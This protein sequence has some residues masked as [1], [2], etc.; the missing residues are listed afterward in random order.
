MRPQTWLIVVLA[1]AFGGVAAAGVFLLSTPASGS[2][3]KSMIVVVT[4]DVPRGTP[5]TAESVAVRP[6]NDQV[7]AGVLTKIADAIGR[8][9]LV[10]LY[11]EEPLLDAKLAPKGAG[12][13]LASLLKRGMRAVTIPTP[14]V[15]TNVAGF[16]EV[17]SHVDILWT[18]TDATRDDRSAG[19]D[20]PLLEDVE[21]LAVDDK[22]DSAATGKPDG[23]AIKSVTVQLK[24]EDAAKL[25]PALTRGT[26]HLSLRNP[27]D[28]GRVSRRPAAPAPPPR[29]EVVA[30]PVPVVPLTIRT[31]RGTREGWVRL[32]ASASAK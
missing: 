13:G 32:G 24:P 26:I 15:A 9:A 17:G 6:T 3:Q 21:V 18:P 2:G 11:K 19:G 8:T 25:A 23:S 16:L 31:L 28:E 12:R 29:R 7:A 10:P 20:G 5:I 1:L 30:A 14:G 4:A 27:G 22:I